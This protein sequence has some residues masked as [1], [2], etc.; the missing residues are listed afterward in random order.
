MIQEEYTLVLEGINKHFGS[1]YANKNV[2]MTVKKGEVRG[3]A[4]E[5]GSG[6]STL[7]SMVAGINTKDSGVMYKNGELYDPK[8]P[9][10][11]NRKKIAIVVQE[12]GLVNGLPAGIN[13]FLGRTKQFSRYGI[14]NIKKM[15]DS[16]NKEL[17]KWGLPKLPL[18]KI[19]DAMNVETRK[20]I[21]LARAL[22]IDPDI[23]ILDEVTQA[24]SR[25]NRE[26]LYKLISAFKSMGRTIILITHDIEEVVEITDSI[27]VLRDGEVVDTVQ[28]KE[29]TVDKIKSMMIGRNITGDYYRA[30][31]KA[32]Y[33]EKIVLEAKG[34][35][36]DDI[37]DVSF[38][39]H[40]GEIL[41]FCGLSDSGIHTIGKAIYGLAN[42]TK[43]SVIL[44]DD[45][46]QIGSRIRALNNGLAYVP[47]D[48]DGE[49]L[50]MQA[51]I[52]DNIC[53]PSLDQIKSVLG[54]LSSR[55]M[56]S[57]AENASKMF[58]VKSTGISQKMS[59]LSG[60]NKQK[61]N[62]GRWLIKDLKVMILDCPTRGVDVG[63]K[64]YI[65]TLMKEAKEKGLS[66]I[67]ISDELTEV[68]GMADRLIVMKRGK[69]SGLINR[70]ADFT[71][72]NIMGV[73]I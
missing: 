17:E 32:I 12:L 36:V 5:N 16:A 21:E 7:L 54:Y 30:D 37:E 45:N 64:A 11:A 40:R 68:L 27:T 39:L 62:L 55:K 73:M 18:H 60:G 19:A 69:I 66:I 22:S 50:M 4:G 26:R 59:G 25:D 23:L 58:E 70:G 15:Y 8:N 3:L 56:N 28:S 48:R 53:L 57:M 41:G 43:G 2:S 44:A 20:M 33:D 49:A 13:V 24:L 47:K 35:F 52:R 14:V 71:E 10:D 1:T 34:V 38:E 65:Y 6:K 31:M 61:I 51:S 63:V 29:V 72:E 46:V 67:L 9:L 42:I